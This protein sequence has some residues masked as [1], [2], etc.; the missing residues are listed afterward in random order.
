MARVTSAPLRYAPF[1]GR[2][3]ALFNLEQSQVEAQFARL[4]DAR[5]FKFAGWPGVQQIVIP[6]GPGLE[7][8]ETLF[9]KCSPGVRI[10]QHEHTAPESVL[11]LEGGYTDDSGVVFHAGMLH[12]MKPGTHHSIQAFPEA[13]CLFASVVHGRRFSSW[14]MRALASI[15]G[16]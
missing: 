8:A 4:G 2:T 16:R 10:P 14:P 7:A 6:G 13:G 1:F 11:L 12:E 9:V 15:L 5:E 3:G